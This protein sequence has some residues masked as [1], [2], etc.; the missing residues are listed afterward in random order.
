MRKPQPLPKD[1]AARLVKE[2][3]DVVAA[4]RVAV[5]VMVGGG[6]L[7]KSAVDDPWTFYIDLRVGRLPYAKRDIMHAVRDLATLCEA[8]GLHRNNMPPMVNIPNLGVF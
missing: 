2:V 6:M 7:G 4:T 1:T 8:A 3:P 5:Y